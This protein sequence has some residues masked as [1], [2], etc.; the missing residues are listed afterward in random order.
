[1]KKI[2]LAIAVVAVL[3]GVSACNKTATKNVD[4]DSIVVVDT[5]SVVDSTVDTITVDSV[6]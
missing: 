1:M 6:K 4:T 2:F 3:C 5:D